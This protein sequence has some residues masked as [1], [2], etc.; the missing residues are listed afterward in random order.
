[1]SDVKKFELGKVYEMM[2]KDGTVGGQFEPQFIGERNAFGIWSVDGTKSRNEAT[3]PHTYL[4]NKF[5]KSEIT[6]YREKPP[7]PLSI[8]IYVNVYKTDSGKLETGVA[9]TAKV[10][11]VNTSN[12]EF[13]GTA[14]IKFTEPK[15]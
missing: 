8:D 13:V 15:E 2:R 14:H 1:M 4:S 6:W 9:N 11:P 10:G 3:L 5:E 7:E 12:R